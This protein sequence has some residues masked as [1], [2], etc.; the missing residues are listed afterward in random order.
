MGW[1]L[2]AMFL[3][4]LL[5][6]TACA[7]DWP[8]FRG[9]R[10]DGC[11]EATDLPTVWG[12]L[13]NPPAW[14]ASIDG[15]GWSSPIVVGGRIWLTSAEATALNAAALARKQ[16]LSRYREDDFQADA[17]VTLL[18]IELDAASG[19]VLRRLELFTCENPAPIHAA[20]SYASPTPVSDGERLYCHFGSLGTV[21]IAL[22]TGR[23]LW[24]QVFAVDD[25]TGPGGSPVLCGE[26]LV[27]A[28]DGADEQ[29]V[30]GV[31]KETGHV[32]WRT[33]RPKIESAEGK[34]RRAFSTPLVIDDQG[35][36]QIVAPAAQWA[37]SYDPATGKEL[38]RVN[39]GSGYAVVPRPVFRQGVVYVATGYPKPELW[40]VRADGSGDVTDTHVIWRYGRQAPEISSPVVV[41]REIYFVSS[42]GIATCLDA[43][44]GEQVWQHRLEGSFASSPLA[45]DGKLYLT[46]HEGTTT[47]LRPGRQYHELAKNQL[48]GRT[49][50][51]PAIAG[52]SLLIRSD[53]ALY[54]IRKTAE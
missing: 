25:I 53:G 13:L 44:T 4:G 49:M 3:I 29:F 16:A 11:A 26:R 6:D 47:V 33:V 10:G 45:A 8:Q 14:Q 19:E 22:D 2:C 24:R 40:A 7:G 41:G 48:F 39:A 52:K 1:S 27:L 50:A 43:E 17:S 21:C 46:N 38:W 34:M 20:N 54:C 31:D 35:R 37:V 30:V 51:S 5:A 42:G 18:A 9:T 28:C 12:G 36:E 15:T 23:T 32:A